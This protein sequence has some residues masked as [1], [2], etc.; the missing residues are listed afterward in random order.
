MADEVDGLPWLLESRC[1]R[2]LDALR[3]HILFEV[4]PLLILLVK[5]AEILILCLCW[6]FKVT[7]RLGV[8]IANL[9]G[10]PHL[11][12]DLVGVEAKSFHRCPAA[13]FK[14]I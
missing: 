4:D 14:I 9:H 10:V 11:E 12:V 6:C 5:L 8:E 2:R 3:T 7:Q 1:D 13:H